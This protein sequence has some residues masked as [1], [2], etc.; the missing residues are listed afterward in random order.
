[1]AG[2]GAHDSIALAE[3]FLTQTGSGDAVTM[4]WTRSADSWRHFDV[5]SQPHLVLLD[6]S[7]NLQGSRSGTFRSDWVEDQLAD[8]G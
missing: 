8:L 4:L 6:S 1:M 7:G 3:S 2:I 5:F